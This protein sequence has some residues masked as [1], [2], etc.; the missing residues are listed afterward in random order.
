MDSKDAVRIP[1]SDGID[2]VGVLP[3]V[4][5]VGRN[6]D[7]NV[8]GWRR[9]LRHDNRR[10]GREYWLIVVLVRDVNIEVRRFLNLRD[11]KSQKVI[12]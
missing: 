11:V 7:K 3:K 2:D 4:I 12:G 9:T 6:G 10:L 5:V 8:T 1:T